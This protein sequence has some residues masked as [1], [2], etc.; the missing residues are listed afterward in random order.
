MDAILNSLVP[1]AEWTFLI[2]AKATVVIGLVLLSQKIF[3]RWL[4]A[5]GRYALWFAVILCLCVPFNIESRWSVFS[6][7]FLNSDLK[8]SV[9][10]PRM[11]APHHPGP[12]WA[13]KGGK[14]R[15]PGDHLY[16]RVAQ[17]LNERNGKYP[18]DSDRQD[19]DRGR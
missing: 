13:N 9:S 1:V 8:S 10:A 2:S 17:K 18:R 5:R 6:P 12:R 4:S 15:R 7:H 19:L 3:N 14:R 11:D 16:R